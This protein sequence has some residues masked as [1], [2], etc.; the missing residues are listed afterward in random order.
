MDVFLAIRFDGGAVTHFFF[1]SVILRGI[2]GT[3]EITVLAMLFGILLGIVLGVMRVS[4]N[5]LLAG[6][7][8]FYVW[9]VR[10]T[11]V[12]IQLLVVAN[13][14]PQ[15][16]GS[17]DFTLFLT[18]FR[19]AVLTFTVNEAAY[20]AEIVR[21]GIQAIEP[22]QM[23]AAKSLGMP[24]LQAMRRI[25]LPQALRVVIPPTGNEVIAMLKNTSIAFAIGFVEL[26]NAA[27]LIYAVNF[28]VMELLVVAS[29]W[30]LLA[31]TAFSVLQAELEARLAI[32][33]RERAIPLTTRVLRTLGRG[34]ER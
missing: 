14:L 6:F 28:K 10:G 25:V 1:N 3:M 22:G 17:R 32:V 12:L 34:R 24:N 33:E 26:T 2:R 19:A 18:P 27:R 13:G 16:V 4:H 11:P 9:F 21:A 30:Y 29:I 15:M 31:T 5:R 8:G 7:A 23:D 20:M